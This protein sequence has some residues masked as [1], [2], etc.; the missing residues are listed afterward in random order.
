MLLGGLQLGGAE[1]N[2]LSVIPHLIEHGIDASLCTLTTAHDSPTVARQSAGITR[3]D[4]RGR[5][6]ADPFA[7]RRFLRLLRSDRID[8]VH[9]EDHTGVLL[10][11][12]ARRRGV[13]LVATRH[14]LSYGSNRREELKSRAVDALL[15]RGATVVAISS[16][17]HA[18]LVDDL[19][20]PPTNVVTIHNGVDVHAFDTP[21]SRAE[22]RG[23]LGW[24]DVPTALFIAALRPGK[25]HEAMLDAAPMLRELAPT[26]RVV[27][28]GSGPDEDSVRARAERIGH[29]DVVGERADIALLLRAADVIVLPSLMEALPTVL[30]EAGAAGLPCVATSVGGVPDIVRDGVTG[31]LVPPGDRSALAER[32]A[33]LLC[34]PAL[35]DSMGAAA[36]LRIREHFSLASQGAET[37]ALYRRLLDPR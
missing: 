26:S 14:V 24:P 17:V 10:G 32:I 6:L 29:V 27:I 28:V 18:H 11:T 30:L 19:G 5:R 7:I 8:L 20:V 3:H 37:A 1:R 34:D 13:P 35:A 12:V 25:G 21:I 31:Y 23:R 22:A 2:T 15:A 33:K 4:L 36:R 16:R 9:A